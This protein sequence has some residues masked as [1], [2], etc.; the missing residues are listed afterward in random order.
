MKTLQKPLITFFWLTFAFSWCVWSIP[1]LLHLTF[2]DPFG[3]LL[4]L[5]GV[6]GPSLIGLLLFDSHRGIGKKGSLFS[7][8]FNFGHISNTWWGI[9][10]LGYPLVCLLALLFTL[11]L[12]QDLPGFVLF[13][14]LVKSPILVIP[15]ALQFL[16]AGPLAEEFGWR[17]FALP[18]MT[19]RFGVTK[20]S[21]LL[22][23]I[24]WAWH[25]PLYFF[26]G[27][28]HYKWGW[29]SQEFWLFFASTLCL[30]ML[31]GLAY[32]QNQN[33]ILAAITMHFIFNVS[34]NLISPIGIFMR[35]NLVILLW[36][37]GLYLYVREKYKLVPTQHG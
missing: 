21:F 7:S 4:Y 19:T 17:G 5:M 18:L 16:L 15:Y 1:I 24:W 33:S 2:D 13:K 26:I 20:S 28:T 30:S 29:F 11:S 10:L 31:I 8:L 35:F 12:G 3:K 27:T 25:L 9:I 32:T 23:I 22:G 36:I 34:M 37:F 6:C 14:Q